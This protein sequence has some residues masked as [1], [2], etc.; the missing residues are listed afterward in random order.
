MCLGL[1]FV[2][3][4]LVITARLSLNFNGYFP[5]APGLAG[6]R[7]SAFWILLELRVMQVVVTTGAIRCAKLQSNH[8]HQ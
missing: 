3:V 6:T 4:V 5:G 1:G 2:V 8:H 7:I